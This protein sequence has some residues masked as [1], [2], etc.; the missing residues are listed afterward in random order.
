MNVIAF[1]Q[2]RICAVWQTLKC[3]QGQVSVRIG[4]IWT[5]V[6]ASI[7]LPPVNWH[8]LLYIR[9][10]LQRYQVKSIQHFHEGQ[11]Q[12][13][14]HIDN[15]CSTSRS[16]STA[17]HTCT[18][19]TRVFPKTCFWWKIM[20]QPAMQVFGGCFEGIQKDFWF[21][22]VLRGAQARWKWRVSQLWHKGTCSNSAK[23]CSCSSEDN[24]TKYWVLATQVMFHQDISQD[25]IIWQDTYR[26]IE[27]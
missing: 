15:T 8:Q 20:A 27:V 1:L 4:T 24:L 18:V 9:M 12:H 19:D 13:K 22:Q 21:W 2:C 11:M 3:I 5:S 6:T 17:Q 25:L 23:L 10:T 26:L 7:S 16:R 14:N